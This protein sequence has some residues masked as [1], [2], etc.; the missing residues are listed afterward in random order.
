MCLTI[1]ELQ[2]MEALVHHGLEL[3]EARAAVMTGVAE[4]LLAEFAATPAS[5][6]QPAFA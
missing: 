3:D 5:P 2:Q 6:A 1:D 4:D